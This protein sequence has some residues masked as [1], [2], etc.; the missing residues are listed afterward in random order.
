MSVISSY[1]TGNRRLYGEVQVGFGDALAKGR[2]MVEVP[3]QR[4][5]RAQREKE[6]RG[7]DRLCKEGL[8]PEAALRGKTRVWSWN[9]QMANPDRLGWWSPCF[10][11]S[12][13]LLQGTQRT[14][15]ADRGEK[16]LQQWTTDA[17]EVIE[18]KVARRGVNALSEGGPTYS[19][20]AHGPTRQSSGRER[21]G[22]LASTRLM[23][24]VLCDSLLP[25][26]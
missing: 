7:I 8:T 14:Y 21:H 13:V 25:I 5:N 17:H 9:C 12:V 26:G 1:G 11:D 24:C 18:F 10:K 3:F 2:S 15:N 6:L 23:G 16:A 19:E 4:L 22:S 20:K